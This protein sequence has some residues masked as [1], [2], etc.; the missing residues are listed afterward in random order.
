MG[1]NNKNNMNITRLFRRYPSLQKGKERGKERENN[2]NSSSNNNESKKNT[3]KKRRTKY[4]S[5]PSVYK[6]GNDFSLSSSSLSSSSVSSKQQ[7]QQQQQEWVSSSLS[8]LDLLLLPSYS[9]DG[10]IPVQA[11]VPSLLAS[12][13]RRQYREQRGK[14]FYFEDATPSLGKGEAFY[15]NNLVGKNQGQC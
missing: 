15:N 12:S 3:K 14:F 4:P 2:N 9:L 10:D 7:E 1:E 11:G 6:Y 5:L 13:F 8:S